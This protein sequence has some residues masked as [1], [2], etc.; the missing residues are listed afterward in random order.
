MKI[1]E[2]TEHVLFCLG[3]LLAMFG[4]ILCCVGCGSIEVVVS[5]E[6]THK[7]VN[8]AFPETEAQIIY[9]SDP[10]AE[11]NCDAPANEVEAAVCLE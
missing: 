6:V 7:I 9:C 3:V 10:G 2:D 4:F 8:C 1:S 5:G 11:I